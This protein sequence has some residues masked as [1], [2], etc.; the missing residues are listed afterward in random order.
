M[1]TCPYHVPLLYTRIHQYNS[2]CLPPRS[3]VFFFLLPTQCSYNT[4][5]KRLFLNLHTV[6]PTS[7]FTFV[8]TVAIA[9]NTPSPFSII[10]SSSSCSSL[11]QHEP[12]RVRVTGQG[13]LRGALF[14]SRVGLF[15]TLLGPFCRSLLGLFLGL[16]F[17]FRLAMYIYPSGLVSSYRG[18]G[19]L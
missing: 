15:R 7:H 12:L 1:G 5:W 3:L 16:G 8:L 4:F 17:G 14:I 9:P 13:T 18:S 2:S 10:Y 11:S 19:R 6:T